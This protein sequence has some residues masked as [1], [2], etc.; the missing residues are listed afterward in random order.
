M[1][2]DVG[3]LADWRGSARD[4]FD[5]R[6]RRCV[7]DARE[8]AS[9]LRHAAMQIERAAGRARLAEAELASVTAAF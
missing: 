9:A 5:T 7:V 6:R 2:A 8:L 1:A 3:L 4:E